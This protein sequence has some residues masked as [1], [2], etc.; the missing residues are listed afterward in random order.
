MIM[1]P[2]HSVP[3]A[4]PGSTY[5]G[6]AAPLTP[7][8]LTH[9]IESVGSASIVAARYAQL[10]PVHRSECGSVAPIPND[11]FQHVHEDYYLTPDD[12]LVKKTSTHSARYRIELVR[13]QILN[14]EWGGDMEKWWPEDWSHLLDYNSYWEK[15]PRLTSRPPIH[16]LYGPGY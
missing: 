13:H 10:V 8:L 9:L 11:D 12:Q 5:S 15:D 2:G 16:T 14:E 1:C 7:E 6:V 4:I 3:R